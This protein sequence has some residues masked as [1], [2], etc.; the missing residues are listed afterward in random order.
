MSHGTLTLLLGRLA[1]LGWLV[2]VTVRAAL[3]V[4]LHGLHVIAAS[5]DGRCGHREGEDS[6]DSCLSKT[7]DGSR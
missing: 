5:G 6:N 2:L 4:L 1:V 7:H 3:L